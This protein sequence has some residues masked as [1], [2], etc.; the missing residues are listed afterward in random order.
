MQQEKRQESGLQV[1]VA[2]PK[3]YFSKM[4]E[5]AIEHR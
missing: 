1:S 4:A 3:K 5:R 2:I